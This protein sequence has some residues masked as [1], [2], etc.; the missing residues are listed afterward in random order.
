MWEVIDNTAYSQ[1]LTELEHANRLT[2]M[3]ETVTGIAHELNQPLNVIGLASRNIEQRIAN[4]SFD[5]EFLKKK[6]HRIDQQV[7]RAA[8]LVSSM[9]S[10]ARIAPERDEEVDLN[11][12]LRDLVEIMTPQLNG[13]DVKL[14]FV[15]DEN[16][17][18]VWANE[19]YITQILTNLII[20]AR[21]AVLSSNLD[22]NYTAVNLFARATA[23]KVFIE[24]V[25]SGPDIPSD[26]IKKVF[27]PFFTTKSDGNGTGLGLSI[28]QTMAKRLGGDIVV[29]SQ[30]QLTI[31]TL[32]LPK[33]D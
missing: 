28:C 29:T 30:D 21:D 19:R 25:N 22:G 11:I 32:S 24:V 7:H 3:G 2:L 12:C 23:K 8:K 15:S 13:D 4:G 1:Q 10:Q 9:R 20:N 27:D 18:I 31:F 17:P 14:N 33:R 6:I 5:V 16:L 26:V